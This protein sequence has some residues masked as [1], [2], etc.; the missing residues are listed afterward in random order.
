MDELLHS[1][2]DFPDDPSQMDWDKEALLF[3]YYMLKYEEQTEDRVKKIFGKLKK[4]LQKESDPVKRKALYE[5]LKLEIYKMREGFKNDEFNKALAFILLVSPVINELE[6]SFET[7]ISNDKYVNDLLET[8][9]E[10]FGPSLKKAIDLLQDK[11][12]TQAYN[13]LVR[14]L[15]TE[16]WR[17]VNEMRLQEFIKKGYQY[18]TTYP[19]KDEKTGDDSWFYY[20]LKQIKPINEPFEYTWEG[21]L[22]SFMAPPDRPNDRNI[23]IP[24]VGDPEKYFNEIGKSE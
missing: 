3:Y 24:Y 10:T 13:K 23:L 22:R 1:L 7:T 9:K 4:D 18:K 14:I 21:E 16:S 12:L 11:A 2:E 6:R 8:Y 17:N 20:D 19:V 5:S 15:R